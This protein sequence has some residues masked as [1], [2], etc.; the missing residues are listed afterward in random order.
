[1]S[2]QENQ[3]TQQEISEERKRA[4]YNAIPAISYPEFESIIN[5]WL[6]LA[7]P[8]VA[9]I[10]LAVI[11]SNTLPSDP[12]WMFL[13]APSGGGKTELMN[14]LLKI[15]DYYPLS[16]LTP[17][18]FLSGYKGKG[19]GGQNPS[20]LKQIA[21]EGS[22]KTP[23]IG[24][25]DFTSLLD[26]NKDDYKA[27]MGQFRELHDGYVTKRTGTGDEITWKG[28]I[29]F[30]AGST[31]ILEYK[32]TTMGAM[33]ERFMSYR[34]KQPKQKDMRARMRQNHGLERQM[35]EEIQNAFAGCYKGI[36]TPD[37]LPTIP[38]KINTMIESLTDFIAI[39][40]SVVLRSFD[41]K[42]EVEWISPSEM[43]TRTYKSLYTLATELILINGGT[44]EEQDT[45]ALKKLAISSIH[46]SRYN[47]IKEIQ[48]YK[49]KVK[50]VTL[51]T[52]TGYPTSTTR[53]HLEDLAAISMDDGDIK[54]V[55]RTHQGV[56]KPD[57]WNLTPEMVEIMKDM[58]EFVE[59]T[60]E[61]S[62]F[63]ADEKD[64]PVGASE[65]EEVEESEVGG[66]SLPDQLDLK[67]I[68]F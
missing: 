29:G 38:D 21:P 40:R 51:A 30:L 13:Q 44:W 48:Q 35:R 54:I 42:R 25:K 6:L 43:T 15:P 46:S 47:L 16:Q 17:N 26:G 49:T 36:I 18:T 60:K 31:P 11:K 64:V 10:I 45:Y 20:L 8:A 62:N 37:K 9:K 50:T 23:T 5:K 1:M 3:P 55:N 28:K 58:D 32:M 59:P 63:T 52:T 67:D 57:L 39:S 33:G 7:D 66:S 2:D 34:I 14:G 41:S 24:F 61:D 56:G 12:V 68:P 65:V 4:E 53:R 27:I 19:D 22:G